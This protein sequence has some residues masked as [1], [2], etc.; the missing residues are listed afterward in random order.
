MKAKK[1]HHTFRP[2]ILSNEQ[3]IAL[4]LVLVIVSIMG[5]L[6]FDFSYLVRVDL[7]S[8]ENYRNGTAAYFLAKSGIEAGRALLKENDNSYDSLSEL[9]ATERP[10]VVVENGVVE[11][12]VSDENRKINV[13]QLA[14]SNSLVKTFR[15]NQMVRLFRI[16]ELDPQIADYITDWIDTDSDGQGEDFYYRSVRVDYQCKN[17]RMDTINELLLVRNITEA[18]FYGTNER[19]GLI[20]FLTTK[21]TGKI[22]INTAGSIVLQTLHD[23][24]TEERAFNI[25]QSRALKSFRRVQELKER[26][27]ETDVED[28]WLDIVDYIS[29][30]SDA[31][32]TISKSQV[33]EYEVRILAMLDKFGQKIYYWR[34]F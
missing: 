32:T 17:G 7:S 16:L 20:E 8:A 13:N 33:G 27:D 34:R 5:Y 28:I 12:L 19:P 3:G 2:T 23:N 14:S 30:V 29:V 25:L 1:G 10:P 4:M 11:I 31:F 15:Y 24:M 21:G 9:W 6:V 18:M 26:K 22:N